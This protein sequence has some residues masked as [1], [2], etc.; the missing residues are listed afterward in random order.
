MEA[1]AGVGSKFAQG[2]LRVCWV[3]ESL[4]ISPAGFTYYLPVFHS[5]LLEGSGSGEKGRS[6]GRSA[7][8]VG[9]TRPA[10]ALN[11]H[12]VTLQTKNHCG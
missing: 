8:C 6:Q 12:D 9:S 11:I 1:P 4:V 3:G 10:T 2:P 7:L 5:R